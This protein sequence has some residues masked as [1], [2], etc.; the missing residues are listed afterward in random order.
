MAGPQIAAVG[1]DGV[2]LWRAAVQ[3]R[4]KHSWPDGRETSFMLQKNGGGISLPYKASYVRK[5]C[6]AL[7]SL[8]SS[9]DQL[10]V[11]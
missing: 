11:L 4:N 1:D 10:R 2:R 7:V 5:C 6:T 9:W 3:I 8:T